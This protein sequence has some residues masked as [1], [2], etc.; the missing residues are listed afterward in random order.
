[1]DE[2][3]KLPIW[4][5]WRKEMKKGS[6]P[7]KVPYKGIGE[8]A[9]STNPAT[10]STYEKL[11]KKF[12]TG[13]GVSPDSSWGIGIVFEKSANII[14]IDFDNC[15]ENG[16]VH[17]DVARFIKLSDTYV[18]YSPSGTGIHLLFQRIGEEDINLIANKNHFKDFAIEVYVSGRYFTFTGNESA[19]SKPLRQINSADF[20]ELLKTMEY[21][22]GKDKD[23]VKDITTPPPAD[24]IK[25]DRELLDKMFASKNGSAIKALW[26]G[27]LSKYNNDTSSGD[28]ALCVHLAFWTGK[29]AEQMQKLWLSSPLGARAKTQER[30]DYRQRTIQSAITA[31]QEVYT[32]KTSRTLVEGWG[33]S[34]SKDPS[35]KPI[36]KSDKVEYDFMLD[37]EGI[38]IL[39]FPNIVRILRNDPYLTGIIRKND[40]SHMVE[41]KNK[42]DAKAEWTAL[43][44]DFISTIREYIC[45]NFRVFK[46][47]SKEM[48]TDAILRVATD[49]RVN[50]PKDYFTSLVWDKTPRLNS[51]LHHAYGVPDDDLHQ[52]I[53]SNW[54][55]GLVKRVIFPGCQFDEVL[56]LV[57]K[58]GYRKSTSLRVLGHPWHVE[59]THSTDNKDFY[60][61]LAQ[62]VIVEFSEG[63]IMDRTSVNRLKAEITKTQDQVRPPYERGIIT[64]PRSC[65]FAIT[66]NRLELKDDTGNRRWLPVELQKI[67]DIDWLAQNKDQLYAEAY[68]RVITNNETT[69]EY[70]K[71]LEN[72]QE[73][74]REFNDSDEVLLEYLATISDEDLLKG[75]LTLT[76]CCRAIN[77]V[78][79]HI[80]KIDELRVAS[81]LRRLYFENLLKRVEGKSVRRWIPTARALDILKSVRGTPQTTKL[82]DFAF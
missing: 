44:D 47:L 26:D 4:V 66:T 63:E 34:G 59:T 39:I 2:I 50:P 1:M 15:V 45:E 64:Y 27:D 49:N 10:W 58:Q 82:K 30:E 33:S 5:L 19:E 48:V 20:M 67:A 7:T 22:W 13:K 36:N 24:P 81:S 32:Q 42:G 41:V 74:Y 21:P 35:V 11:D 77:P 62:N 52:S 23:I 69:H 12:F 14:G 55:K 28:Y 38:P 51:W 79:T 78:I 25:T 60:L 3:K 8:Y 73:D 18:E 70:H 72:L 57:S 68:H 53:G 17:Q 65:V 16:K 76:M 56:A 37:K 31:T 43:N 75:E 80:T 46:K 29:N 9:S 61:I 54:M 40:F 71:T 6:K